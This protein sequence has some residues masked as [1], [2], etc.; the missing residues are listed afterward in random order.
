MNLLPMTYFVE[1]A[2]QQGISRA[3]ESL[4]ITQQTLSSHIA[5]MEKELDCRLFVRR[6]KFRLTPEGEMFL[7][8]CQRFIGLDRNMRQE[9]RDMSGEV[10]GI[11]RAG[12]SQ[13][14]SLILMPEL[15]TG[16]QKKYPKVRVYL[17]EITNDEL[18]SRI[19]KDELDLIIGDVS[20]ERPDLDVEELY[21]ER[22]AVIIPK[23]EEYAPLAKLLQETGDLGHLASWPMITNTRNDIVGRY[24]NQVLLQN[25]IPPNIAAISDIAGTCLRLCAEG[26]GVYLCPDLYVRYYREVEE[27]CIIIPL[28]YSYSIHMAMRKTEHRAAAA[29]RFAAYCRD[30]LTFL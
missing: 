22:M 16:F 27:K 15:I 25:H 21:R 4:Q 20:E 5:A 1:V 30:Y 12:I 13:T 8:Y 18:L 6:P 9:L 7:E 11:V 10:A 3:A 2:K 14:R 17:S 24:I 23:K 29:D 28:P 19:G 26:V